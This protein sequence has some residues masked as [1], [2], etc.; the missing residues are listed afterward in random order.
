MPFVCPSCEGDLEI[1]QILRLPPE[2]W[3]DEISIQRE[4]QNCPLRVA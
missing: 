3:D 4:A 2:G 1:V